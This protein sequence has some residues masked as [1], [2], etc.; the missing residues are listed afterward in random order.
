MSCG[1]LL[2]RVLL[3]P[4]LVAGGPGLLRWCRVCQRAVGMR[5]RSVP[6]LSMT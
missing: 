2:P 3:A 4:G 5:D 1:A 6:R